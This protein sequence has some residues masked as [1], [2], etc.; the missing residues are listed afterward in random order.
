MVSTSGGGEY[1]QSLARG[2]EVIRVFGREPEDG[3]SQVRA[4]LSLT[5]VAERAGLS[6]A[7]ARRLL[8]TLAE[9]GY[10]TQHGR[11]FALTPRVLELGYSYFASAD[12]PQLIQPV[13]ER[14]SAEVGES[15]SASV[16]D[17]GEIVYIARA[18][19]RRIM[20]INIS[21][22]TRLPAYA[23][24]MGRIHLAYLPAEEQRRRLQP[25]LPAL[26]DHT[27]TDP[28]ELQ[29]RLG[30]VREQ[31]WSMVEHELEMGLRS[32]AVPVFAPEGHVAA[33]LNVA[34]GM[35]NGLDVAPQQIESRFVAPLRDA[36][37]EIRQVLGQQR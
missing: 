16:L 26:T 35:A 15:V 10:V 37:E 13:V 3:E 6:R 17:G 2:L 18:H 5:E 29:R 28:R 4:E 9:M 8:L 22:G 33:A 7:T 36:A 12:L 24:S 20:R 31:G 1:V 34:L 23:T 11:G 21:A 19:T 25:P 14:V 32:V 30:E 27:V